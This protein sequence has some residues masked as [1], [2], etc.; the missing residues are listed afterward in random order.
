MTKNWRDAVLSEASLVRDALLTLDASSLQVVLVVNTQG[1]LLGVVTDGDIRRGFLRGISMDES[2]TSVMNFT[3]LVINQNYNIRTAREMM[4]KHDVHHLPVVDEA[5]KILGLLNLDFLFNEISHENIVVLMAGGLGSRLSPLTDELPKPLLKVAGKAIAELLLEELIACGFKNFYL[6]VNYK[7]EMIQEHF[8][9]G[10]HWKSNIKY[11]K[12]EKRM[13]TAGSLGMLSE[14]INLPVIVANADIITRLD[15]S[16]ALDFHVKS[17]ASVTICVRNY[18]HTVPYGVI[19]LEDDRFIQ[20]IEKP[21]H[22]YFVSAGIYII[23]PEVLKK[24]PKNEYCDMPDLITGLSNE[25]YTIS[26]YPICE[27]WLDV[28]RIEDLEKAHNDA[29]F[30]SSA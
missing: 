9:D 25:G 22:D 1:Q 13:G 15:F 8:Q 7:A 16:Q 28:G 10:S 3:P 11:I 2:V 29:S 30:F 27:Y 17:K 6:S 12:E 14:E 23:N 5:G 4:R 19:K 21:V 24:I 20:I 18:Q 26:V